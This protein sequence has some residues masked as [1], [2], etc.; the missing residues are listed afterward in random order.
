MSMIHV[1]QSDTSS[2]ESYIHAHCSEL[3]PPCVSTRSRIGKSVSRKAAM[4]SFCFQPTAS[5]ASG[6]F[7]TERIFD[8]CEGISVERGE[9]TRKF[10]RL[11]LPHWREMRSG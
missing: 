11:P 10:K 5:T 2:P 6:E 4:L 9:E 8:P 3:T 1:D 7:P